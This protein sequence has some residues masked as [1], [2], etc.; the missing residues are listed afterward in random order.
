MPSRNVCELTRT[1]SAKPPMSRSLDPGIGAGWWQSAGWTSPVASRRC[2]LGVCPLGRGL[3]ASVETVLDAPAAANPACQLGQTR[4]VGRQCGDRVDG[5][6]MPLLAADGLDLPVICMAWIAWGKLIPGLRVAHLM[7]LMICRPL[8]L[9]L[10]RS[11]TGTCSQGALGSCFNSVG[12]I[13][14]TVTILESVLC[15]T[16]SVGVSRRALCRCSC[17]HRYRWLRKASRSSVA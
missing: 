10:L 15:R 1:T 7:V 9:A 8:A 13:P 14:F 11:P 12:W 2:A 17:Q 4:L 5:F 3:P 16:L 6:Q